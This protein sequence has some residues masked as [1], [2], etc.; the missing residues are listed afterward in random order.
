M[1]ISYKKGERIAGWMLK[2]IDSL[3][4]IL[5]FHPLQATIPA[6]PY[7]GHGIRWDDNDTSGMKCHRDLEERFHWSYGPYLMRDYPEQ[8][9]SMLNKII[10]YAN[11]GEDRS[12]WVMCSA[13][14]MKIMVVPLESISLV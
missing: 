2:L 12:G 14:R 1:K 3:D 4:R 6:L 7:V 8:I 11:G 10:S 5:S 9:N 13:V